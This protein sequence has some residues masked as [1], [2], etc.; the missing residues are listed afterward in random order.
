[1]GV[2]KKFVQR[3]EGGEAMYTIDLNADLGEGFGVYRYGADEQLLPLVTSANIACGWHGGD[4]GVMRRAAALAA[5]SG[6]VIGAHPGYPDLMGFGRRTLAMNPQEVR[7]ALLYQIG[8]LDGVCRGE[9]TRVAYVKPH[10]SLY[11]MAA[12]DEALAE[13]VVQAI[14]DYGER[15]ILLCPWNSALEQAAQAASVP[16][17]REFFADRAYQCDG[18][19]VHRADPGAVISDVETICC[20]V[21][22]AIREGTV[23]AV[24]GETISVR[25]DSIC[26]HG[27]NPAAV[28]LA[29]AIRQELERAGIAVR[30][31]V[32]ER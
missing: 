17:A 10:G 3:R 29:H 24:T 28:E 15:L 21:L 8:A 12:K 22:R 4:P 23:E 9:K 7:D 20:R 5:K 26:L 18:S 31:F 6:V 13:G 32:G 27:D 2:L 11:N 30:S 16:I 1:M 25:L 19:L 14:K